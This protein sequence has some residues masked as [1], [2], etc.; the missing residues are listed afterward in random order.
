M[1]RDLKI[2]RRLVCNWDEVDKMFYCIVQ[3][4]DDAL[5]RYIDA[6][7]FEVEKTEINKDK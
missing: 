3:Q 6:S 5:D 7:Y 2:K 1:A 4:W